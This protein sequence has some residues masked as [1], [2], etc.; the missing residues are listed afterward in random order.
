MFLLNLKKI[1]RVLY[2]MVRQHE[3]MKI[4]T[5]RLDLKKERVLRILSFEKK[6]RVKGKPIR[7]IQQEIKYNFAI[8][9]V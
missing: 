8:K 1:I 5:N 2:E 4:L 7:L 3:I 6:P 9:D